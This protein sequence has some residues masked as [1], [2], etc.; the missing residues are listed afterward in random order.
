MIVAGV[1]DLLVSLAKCCQPVPC[2]HIIGFITRGRGV[3]VHRQNC[4]NVEQLSD[5]ERARLID[6]DWAG[7]TSKTYPVDIHIEAFDRPGLIRD[8]TAILAHE[9]MNVLALNT[10]TN[11]DD[12]TVD[13]G[14][15]I[16]IEN[17]DQLS[18]VLNRLG[19]LP[20]VQNVSRRN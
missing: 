12:L 14:M 10:Q 2:D 17:L 18:R 20:N 11:S 15:K 8:I 4:P 5:E 1:G 7:Q 3:T 16:E 13:F 9:R 19:S 6:V